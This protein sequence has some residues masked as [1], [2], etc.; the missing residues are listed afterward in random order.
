MRGGVILTMI[1]TDLKF[2]L[3][4]FHSF[5]PLGAKLFVTRAEGDRVIECNGRPA[6]E[7]Y[8]AAL[9]L[10]PAAAPAD[11]GAQPFSLYPL[12]HRSRDGRFTL[13][14]PE[15]VEADGS[16]R[17]PAPVEPDRVLYPM[18][19]VPS[20]DLWRDPTLVRAFP[21]ILDGVAAALVIRNARLRDLP[22][23]LPGFERGAEPLK[24]VEI[25]CRQPLQA[26]LSPGDAEGET[27]HLLLAVQREF[28][29]FAVAAAENERLLTEVMRLKDLHEKIFDGI[30]Y[31]IAVIDASRGASS[32]PTTPTGRSSAR[33]AGGAATGRAAARGAR[34]PPRSA[35][36]APPRSPSRRGSRS[37]G[38]SCARRR[39]S[40]T[41]T[42]STPS[43]CATARAP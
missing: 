33:E 40:R 16:L 15:A 9:G 41:G 34:T 21:Q 24:P 10:D 27:G 11:S 3:E 7:A 6:I 23:A 36:P 38:R 31:G 4:R 29:P 32:S 25:T 8:R 13:L 30:G 17:F 19:A 37:A 26:H 12:A 28:E 18:K 2:T 1:K 5:E 39:G 42:G 35:A 14:V 20:P 22:S 43:R